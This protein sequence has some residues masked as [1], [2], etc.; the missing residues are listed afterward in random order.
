MACAC[1]ANKDLQIL[2]KKYGYKVNPSVK[3]RVGFY[4]TEGFKGL[5]ASVIIL[6]CTP[7]LFLYVSYISLFT[8][9]RKISVSKLLRLK[10][11]GK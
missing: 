3:E 6:L 7:L 5:C 8:K 9:D 11:A 2:H 4:T 1:K 10:N